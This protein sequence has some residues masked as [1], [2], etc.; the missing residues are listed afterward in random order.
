M[1]ARWSRVLPALSLYED[2]S[3]FMAVPSWLLINLILFN[4]I[5]S[6]K[7]SSVA[8]ELGSLCYEEGNLYLSKGWLFALFIE[9]LFP[10]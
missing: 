7:E 4:R 5:D 9:G 1:Q 2:R 8:K 6:I 3:L 10:L